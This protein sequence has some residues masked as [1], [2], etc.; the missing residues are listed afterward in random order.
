[1]PAMRACLGFMQGKS[2]GAVHDATPVCKHLGQ[3]VDL[4]AAQIEPRG[5]EGFESNVFHK[6]S[7]MKK[8]SILT[9]P[10]HFNFKPKQRSLARQDLAS[11]HGRLVLSPGAA[12]HGNQLA[13]CDE[14]PRALEAL[15]LSQFV[16]PV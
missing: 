5:R 11:R 6:K 12:V 10:S 7:P 4:S 3:L 14:L 13:A 2:L 15:S 8:A 9:R 1:M 16:S